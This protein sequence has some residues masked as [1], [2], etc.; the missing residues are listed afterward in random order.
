MISVKNVLADMEKEAR[1]LR[2]PKAKFS[3]AV[4]ESMSTN[5][6][7]SSFADKSCDD[8]TDILRRIQGA[9]NKVAWS[10]FD[11]LM[12]E[13][14]SLV[15]ELSVNNVLSQNSCVILKMIT[16]QVIHSEAYA[17]IWTALTEIYPVL[18]TAEKTLLDKYMDFY[19]CNDI[20]NITLL[21][22]EIDFDRAMRIR[23]RDALT[24]FLLYTMKHS[25]SSLAR[26][27]MTR[28]LQRILSRIGIMVEKGI[29]DGSQFDGLIRDLLLFVRKGWEVLYREE[30]WPICITAIEKLIAFLRSRVNSGIVVSKKYI[31]DLR[32]ALKE[33]IDQGRYHTSG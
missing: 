32:D 24:T 12:D 19:D 4:R 28:E 11:T 26:E 31:L 5:S 27:K 18:L 13:I 9:I 29:C 7:T 16:N 33:I 22:P 21:D 2:N 20:G 25:A 15:N 8:V 3:V 10:N 14:T 23:R 30:V 6:S 17:K 1:E